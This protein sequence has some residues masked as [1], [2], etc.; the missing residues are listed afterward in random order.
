MVISEG[1]E[2]SKDQLHSLSGFWDRRIIFVVGIEFQCCITK[3]REALEDGGG[4]KFNDCFSE[5]RRDQHGI[6]EEYGSMPSY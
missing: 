6:G 5:K 3:D 4:F 1:P 2:V